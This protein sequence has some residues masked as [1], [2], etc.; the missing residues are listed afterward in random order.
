MPTR[1]INGKVCLDTGIKSDI[2]IVITNGI[3][4]I[5][6]QTPAN[7][8]EQVIDASGSYV[9]PGFIEIHTHGA[10]LFEFTM[11]KFNPATSTFE[12]SEEIYSTE[13]AKYAQL[14]ESTGVTRIYL[15]TWAAPIE[16]QKFCFRQ[17]KTYIESEN[18]GYKGA[19]IAGGLLEGTFINPKNAGAQNPN[20]VFKPDISLFDEINE[21]HV[22][23][24]INIVPDSGQD[25]YE[26]TEYCTKKG[27]SVGAG[28][29]DATYNQFN[30]AIKSGLKYCIHFL[31]GPI[32]HNYKIFEGGGAV[33]A[34]LCTDI[35][36]ELILDGVHVNP[37][38]VR[39]VMFR[40]GSDKIIAVTDA[41]FFSQTEGISEFE[42]SGIKGKISDD[43]KFVYV[44]NK[45][46][47][48]LFSSILTM[49]KAF[50]NL[51]SWLTCD[52]PGIW[53]SQHEAIDFEQALLIASRCCSKNIADMLALNS[54][55]EIQTGEIADGKLADLIIADIEG[56]T[57]NY[58]INIKQT[59]T[60]RQFMG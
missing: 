44:A 26:L 31:N 59:Y 32:G 35:Y 15:G 9:L 43:K 1:I 34:V 20:F 24:L 58:T 40:K 28:H 56:K 25:A 10:G 3:C 52:M 60:H 39:D 37:R 51:L 29:T 12:S 19:L 7:P 47:L 45:E 8:N 50:S 36:A 11:G 46:K 27:I 23:K 6:S 14:R 30:R 18:N 13:L 53:I 41:M 22:I 2:D 57:G 16:R 21:S 33:E 55:E 48:T 17:L 5:E 54:G 49:D 4:H 42:I 38:Y